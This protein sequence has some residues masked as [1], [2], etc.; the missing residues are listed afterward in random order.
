MSPLKSLLK[1]VPPTFDAPPANQLF[2][3]LWLYIPYSL[4]KIGFSPMYLTTSVEPIE[5]TA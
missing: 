3:N 4:L 5:V 1:I 2:P